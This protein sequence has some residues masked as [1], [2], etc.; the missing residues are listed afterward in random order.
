MQIARFRRD[1]WESWDL[2][3]RPVITSGMPVLIDDDLRFEDSP[4]QPRATAAMNSWLRQLPT[5]GGN[6]PHT[7]MVYA[8]VLRDWANFLAAHKISVFD[9]REKLKDGLGAYST[10]RSMGPVDARLEATTWNQHI[11]VLGAFYRWACAEGHAQGE[12]FTYRTAVTAFIE[13]KQ[14][15][16][17]NM[18]TRRTPK[19][20]V[21]VKYLDD[22]F[23]NLF[24]NGLSGLTPEG[25]ESEFRGWE[26]ARNRAVG[27]MALA[28]GLRLQEFSSL[29]VWE[30]PPL[31]RTKSEMPVPFPVPAAV[32]KGRKFRTT[33]ISYESLARVHRYMELDRAA[34]VDASRWM[35]TAGDPLLVS[36]PDE[37]GGRV[38]GKRITWASLR[39]EER[40]RLVAPHGGTCLLS[41]TRAGGPFTAWSTVFART[42]DRIRERWEPRF[43]HVHPH[44]LRHTFAMQ[45]ME[46]LVAG[47]YT[48]L[49]RMVRDTEADHALALYLSKADPMMVLR[50]LLGH[51]SVMTTEKYLRRIDT[52]RIF[53]D[54]YEQ[55]G[56]DY[57]LLREN[58]HADEE[59]ALELRDRDI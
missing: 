32:T 19:A 37:R 6:S 27:E 5:R 11:S 48:Q 13:R 30:I 12:P 14:Q 36:E 24:L 22:D 50:D 38:N 26:L 17:V 57:D 59:V 56:R 8:R 21:A 29:L 20:H 47:Y 39:P 15:R 58:T 34:N 51:S 49:A 54:A 53:R 18:A 3:R 35:P 2:S 44:R 4:G 25:T 40:R 9:S 28:T 43:P 55:A 23:A 7:W 42:A 41:V 45:T 16:L 52:T 1:G 33:W 46:R 31:P 10:Y